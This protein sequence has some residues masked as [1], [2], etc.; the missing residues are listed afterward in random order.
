MYKFAKIIINWRIKAKI[1]PLIGEGYNILILVKYA[2]I[3]TL[4]VDLKMANFLQ[5]IITIVNFAKMNQLNSFQLDLHP[6]DDKII[7]RQLLEKI[8]RRISNI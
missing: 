7:T 8:E 3:C 1:K 6:R 2:Q 4:N 5:F